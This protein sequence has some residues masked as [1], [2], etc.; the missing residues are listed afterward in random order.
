MGAP[1]DSKAVEVTAA[2]DANKKSDDEKSKK[3]KKSEEELKEDAMSDED[4]ELKERLETC[5]STVINDMNE[6]D[7]TIPI[8][9][10]A[11]D[12]IVN[13]LRTATAS[14]TSVPKPLKFLRPHFGALKTLYVS[15]GESDASQMD[16]DSLEFRARL[17]DVLAVLAMTMGKHGTWHQWRRCCS[18]CPMPC[19]HLLILFSFFL[20]TEERESLRF[21]LSGAKDY[22]ALAVM[23]AE[24]KN[25]AE[26]NLGSWGH[27]FVRSL[28]GEI[29]QEYNQRVLDGA[30]P[31][32]DEPFE[33]LLKFVYVIVPFHLTHNAEAEAIDLLIEVQR[34][35]YLLELDTIHE[36][37]YQRICLYLIKT[38]SYMSDPDDLMVC[39][40][41]EPFRTS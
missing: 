17:A 31:E 10:K 18:I 4:K 6:D 7:V 40:L 8:R 29:G 20:M 9:L 22:D 30:D 3:L 1:K 26:E 37:N 34:L 13:E 11:L 14:M 35:K 15:F 28:A 2:T 39:R 33:D 41:K 32:T 24:P 23:G 25:F 19:T 36:D 27:E 38:A 21:K 12:V 5:V 16:T